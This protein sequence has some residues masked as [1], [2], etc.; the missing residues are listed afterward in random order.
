MNWDAIGAVGETIGAIAVI[1]TL[2]YLAS[3]I[4]QLKQQT[5]QNTMQHIADSMNQFMDTLASEA[6]ASLVVRRVFL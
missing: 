2:I 6:N 3:Q 4:R 1:A 5:A